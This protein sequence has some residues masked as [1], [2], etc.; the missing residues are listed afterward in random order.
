M[1]HNACEL[2][3]HQEQL[4]VFCV[5]GVLEDLVHQNRIHAESDEKD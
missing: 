2:N 1:I 3:F 5:Q 4:V